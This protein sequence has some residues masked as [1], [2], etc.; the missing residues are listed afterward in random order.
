MAFYIIRQD[1]NLSHS[2]D[3]RILT[4]RLLGNSTVG[5]F[6][7]EKNFGLT[8]KY[9]QVKRHEYFEY[10]NYISVVECLFFCLLSEP[11]TVCYTSALKYS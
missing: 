11:S 1:S 6:V 7:H 5:N 10:M 8:T 9:D 2:S 4:A 3:C